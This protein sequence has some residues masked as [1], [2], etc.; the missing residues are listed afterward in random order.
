MSKAKQQPNSSC[1]SFLHI[2]FCFACAFLLFC[3]FISAT[4]LI[5]VS[6][7]K[8]Y[9]AENYLKVND[10]FVDEALIHNERDKEVYADLIYSSLL[11]FPEH[12][13]PFIAT[14]WSV[15]F[16]PEAP[17]GAAWYF[18][19]GLNEQDVTA[20]TVPSIKTVFV[21]TPDPALIPYS[22]LHE[23]CHVLAFEYGEVDRSS[24]FYALYNIYKDSYTETFPFAVP[25]YSSS[26]PSEF[27]AATL[28]SYLTERDHLKRSAPGIVDYMDSLLSKLP[29]ENVLG[30]LGVRARGFLRATMK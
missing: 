12:V 19:D 8:K 29:Y 10:F 25:H 30:K 15:V 5:K 26:S 1:H 18:P 16:T 17:E 11:L 4:S 9:Y 21:L 22:L 3:L 13:R 23:F 7:A 24:Q 6:N 28:S 14:D 20:V 27:F 2:L